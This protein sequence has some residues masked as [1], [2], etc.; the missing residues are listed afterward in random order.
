MNVRYEEMTKKN[1]KQIQDMQQKIFPESTFRDGFT[2]LLKSGSF[3]FHHLMEK[4]YLV[5]ADDVAAGVCG[6]YIPMD[7]EEHKSIFLN[8]FGVLPSFR[9]TGLGTKIITDCMEMSK[10]YM[11]PPYN[12]KFFRLYTSEFFNFTAQPL[13]NRIMTLKEYYQN[14]EMCCKKAIDAAHKFFPKYTDEECRKVLLKSITVFSK[15]LDSNEILVPWNNRSMNLATILE[16][17]KDC[18]K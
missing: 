1:I 2:A 5:Y 12:V 7:V 9:G 15:S 16:Y 13:Y 11:K 8:W 14:D 4:Y 10:E 6:L 18:R 17:E 3:I